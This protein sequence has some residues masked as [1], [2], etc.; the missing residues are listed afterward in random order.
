[1]EEQ[2]FFFCWFTDYGDVGVDELG[3]VIKDD[4]WL[5]LL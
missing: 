3:E 4:I 2:E 1:M 5:N